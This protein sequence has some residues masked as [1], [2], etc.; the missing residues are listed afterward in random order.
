MLGASTAGYA[1]ALAGVAGLQSVAEAA[2]AA[3][4]AP[5]LAALDAGVAVH[6][7]LDARIDAAR[8]QYASAAAAYA[9]TGRALDELHSD[10]GRLTRIVGEIEG[11]SRAL[12]ATVALPPVRVSVPTARTPTTQATTRAS[13][14]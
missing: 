8:R 9:T 3:A 7:Q 11:D 2:I 14:G 6:D 13:G 5:A 4:R 12:P 1:L 10:L